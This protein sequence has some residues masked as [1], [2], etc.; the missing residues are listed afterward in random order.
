VTA[1]YSGTPLPQKLGIKEGSVVA[2]LSAPPE[3]A[4]AL[5]SLPPGVEVR[6]QARGQLDVIVFFTMRGVELVRRFGALQRALA[7]AGGLWVGYPKKSSGV[8]TDLSFGA[9]QQVGLDAGLVDNKTCAI[10]E[11]WSGVRFV[12]RLRDR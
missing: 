4:L 9:V 7:P 1:G 10:D 6:R 12:R 3:F 5:G 8:A 11:V 2:F